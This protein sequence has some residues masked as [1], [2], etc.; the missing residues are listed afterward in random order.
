MNDVMS[1]GLHRIWKD[2]YMERLSPAPGT[3]LLDVA[4]GTGKAQS[5]VD[6]EIYIICIPGAGV[7]SLCFL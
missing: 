3:K 6:K 1:G 7:F 2:V 5:N 4:G